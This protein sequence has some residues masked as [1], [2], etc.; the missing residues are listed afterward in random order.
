[1]TTELSSKPMEQDLFINGE[2]VKSA[3]GKSFDVINPATGEVLSKVQEADKE[4]IDRAV[5][6]AKAAFDTWSETP[7]STRSAILNKVAD[8]LESRKEEFAKLE[9]QNTGKPI[10]ES[11]FLDL[12]LAIDC[13]RFYSAAARMIRGETIPVASGQ[14]VYTLKDPVGVVGQIIPWN[15][16]IL[17]SAWKLGPALAAGNTVVLKPA[18][19]TPVT[20]LKLGELFNEAG[21]PPGVLNIVPGFGETAGAALVNHPDVDK[22]AFTGETKTGRLIMETASKTLKRVSLELGGKAPNIV[23]EDADLDNAVHGSLF[24]V[25]LNQGQAC[26]SGSRLY[27][28]ESIYDK[29]MEKLLVAAQK[30][31]VGNPLDMTTKV[32][33]LASKEQFDKVYSYVA[34]GKAEGAKLL[35]GGDK[36]GGD[37]S[38]GFFL[39]PTIFE[40]EHTMRITQEEVFGPFL[41][42]IKFKDVN[43]AILKANDS[44]YGLAAALWTKNVNTAHTV[45]RKIKAGTIWVNTYNFL[46]NEVPFGGFKNSGF[47]RELGLQ[48]LDMYTESKSIC[49]DL[50]QH[51]NWFG[52]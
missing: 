33:A 51:P 50:G 30:I 18:E 4:D 34:I 43:D 2:Y 52:L 49:I 39:N 36:A 1:M 23:F 8:L 9:T 13:F 28:Q 16:P 7:A 22:I 14:L 10:V 24:A 21:L 12:G 11:M 26:V 47:G 38:N 25:Y 46:F 19:Q 5:K 31:K 41:S 29:F 45:A 35:L 20:A 17:M 3:S 48:A 6:S 42:V 27:V 15:F 44:Q 37:L 40:A 32:G